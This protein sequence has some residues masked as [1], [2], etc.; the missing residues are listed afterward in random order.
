MD[1]GI[2]ISVAVWVSLVFVVYFE[3]QV[4]IDGRHIPHAHFE[5]FCSFSLGLLAEVIA[6]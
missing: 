3:Y 1:I 6:R 5:L 2:L 4:L